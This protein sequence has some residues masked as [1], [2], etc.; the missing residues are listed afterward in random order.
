[1]KIC[2]IIVMSACYIIETSYNMIDACN[3]VTLLMCFKEWMVCFLPNFVSHQDH[4][5]ITLPLLE[6]CSV[7]HVEVMGKGLFPEFVTEIFEP[8]GKIVL[9]YCPNP[10]PIR[11]RSRSK[12]RPLFISRLSTLRGDLMQGPRRVFGRMPHI[13]RLIRQ[14]DESDDPESQQHEPEPT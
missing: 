3:L 12:D 8:S 7:S 4:L 13:F 2:Y 11:I 10:H 5:L 6:C 14:Q 9:K 1:M